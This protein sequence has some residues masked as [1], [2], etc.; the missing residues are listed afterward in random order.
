MDTKA[1]LV[2]VYG[3]YAMRREPLD[4]LDKIQDAF[5]SAD[6]EELRKLAEELLSSPKIQIFV[7]G[8]KSIPVN[9]EG[10]QTQTLEQNLMDVAQKIGLP[11]KEVELR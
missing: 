1:D 11:Y 3:R 9:T 8:D 2:R 10:G 4:T 5:F 6:R 7:V